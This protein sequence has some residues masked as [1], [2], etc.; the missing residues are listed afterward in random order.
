[1]STDLTASA[2]RERVGVD[3]PRVR[4][5][6]G[7]A[8]VAL[9][10]VLALLPFLLPNAYWTGT[11]TLV[12][13]FWILVSGLTL[14]VGYAGQ[15]SVG[16]VGLLAVGAY[17]ACSVSQHFGIGPFLALVAA[18][19]VGAIAGLLIGLP[20]L[21]LRRFYFAMATLGFATVVSQLA[22]VW[23]GVTGG[24]TGIAAPTFSAPFDT[25]G[26]FYWLV[27]LIAL[28]ATLLTWLYGRSNSGRALIAIRDAEVAAE[29][30]GVPTFRLKLVA[31][32]FS[33]LLAGVSGGLYSSVQ[34]YI[35]PDAFTFDLS[36]LF[37]TAVL[38]GGRGRI[39]APAVATAVLVI[40]PQLAAP[41]EKWSAFL[42]AVLLL[43]VVLLLPNG[44]GGLVDRLTERFR[45]KRDT[46]SV[47]ELTNLSSRWRP[48]L[49]RPDEPEPEALSVV[50]AVKEFGG[51]R[52][53]DR[54]D[55]SLSAGSV[56][57]LIGPN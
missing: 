25:P 20:S 56:H 53:L 38:L 32:T 11:A 31:F 49:A 37:F 34:T 45:G 39:L 14:V 7:G 57:G 6:G 18:A 12:L 55:L 43:V 48:G 22:V 24:G 42:Y 4:L 15:L 46:Q 13:V 9:V 5:R 1:M 27:L 35:T 50:G 2:A 23:R 40:L 33:G 21:R 30:V 28:V 47:G 10:V 17:T 36:M 26:G 19:L 44:V 54:A 29:S 3:G 51:V 52:A 8:T 41:L 16:H